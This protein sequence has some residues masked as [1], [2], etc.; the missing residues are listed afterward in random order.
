MIEVD[1]VKELRRDMNGR[2]EEGGVKCKQVK[3]E[4]DRSQQGDK[5]RE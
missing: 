1:C 3:S 5:E 4:G 2:K